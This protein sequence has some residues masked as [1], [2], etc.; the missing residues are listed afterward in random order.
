VD[1]EQRTPRPD[2]HDGIDAPPSTTLTEGWALALLCAQL[3]QLRRDAAA[4]YWWKV[5]DQK[6]AA[7]TDGT[8]SPAAVCRQLG[9]VG[10][11]A[12]VEITTR[13]GG[14]VVTLPGLD[15]VELIGDYTCPADR[16]PR[17]DGRDGQG[18]PPVCGLTNEPMRFQVR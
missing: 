1:T 12:P 18:R 15:P 14:A 7:L 10:D 16:C 8:G 6:L 3:P 4:H 17:R 9:L 5:L 2:G 13:G 11:G